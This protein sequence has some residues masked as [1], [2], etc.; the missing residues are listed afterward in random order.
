MTASWCSPFV[1]IAGQPPLGTQGT[2]LQIRRQRLGRPG[3]QRAHE[4]DVGRQR[5]RPL[6]RKVNV[7]QV[8]RGAPQ[9][10]ARPQ[11]DAVLCAER[12]IDHPAS[13][14][15]HLQCVWMCNKALRMHGQGPSAKW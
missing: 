7:E 2:R 6:Q 4:L 5:A 1:W 15:R 11:V 10:R 3:Q 8:H 12:R 14:I 9:G 13:G